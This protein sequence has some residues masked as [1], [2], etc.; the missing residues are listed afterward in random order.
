MPK[1]QNLEFYITVQQ[2]HDIAIKDGN[3]ERDTY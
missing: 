2:K 1:Q 3:I